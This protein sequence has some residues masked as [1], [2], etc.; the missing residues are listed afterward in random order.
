MMQAIEEQFRFKPLVSLKNLFSKL[1]G[2]ARK[3]A[4]VRASAHAHAAN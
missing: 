2:S 4:A 1:S 3:P